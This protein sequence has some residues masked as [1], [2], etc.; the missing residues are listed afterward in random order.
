MWVWI[1]S[2]ICKFE[3]GMFVIVHYWVFACCNLHYYERLTYREV[4][5]I[6]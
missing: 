5:V 2:E 6:G 1:V 3:L 4:V